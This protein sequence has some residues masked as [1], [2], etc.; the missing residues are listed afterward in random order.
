MSIV[1][2]HEGDNRITLR[3]LIDQGVRVH[4]VCTDPPYGLVSIKK[5]FGKA[6]AAPAKFGTDGAFARAGA[7]F[8]GSEWD[9]T[10][11]ERDPEFWRLIWEILLP[12]GYCLAFS[13]AS[14]GH[15]QACA[16]ELAGFTMHPMIGWTFGS[17][18]PK[19]HDAAKAIDK[20]LGAT[21]SF[22][23]PKSDAHAGWIKRGRMRGGEDALN[24]EG[25]QRPW[26]ED[27]QA[28]SN[29]ARQYIPATE[30]G[31]QWDGWSYGAQALKPALEPI[32]VGQKPFSEKNG[33]LN[34]LKHGA[35]AV[36]IDGCRVP[37]DET[38]A[39][40]GGRRPDT[41]EGYQ[42]PNASMFQDK[43]D[44]S[45]PSLGRH[46][47]NLITD[48]SDEVRALFPDSNGQQG[49]VR[50]T[51]PS[52][53]TDEIYGKFAGRVPAAKRQDTDTSA[54]RFF[55]AFPLDAES[56][57]YHAKASKRDRIYECRTCGNHAIG[58]KPSCTCAPNIRTHPTV[59][60]IGLM[61]HLVKLVTPPGGTVLDCFAGTGT[62][63]RAAQ[64]LGFN[65][66]LLEADPDFCRDIRLRCQ[67][68][69]EMN[70]ELTVV[71]DPHTQSLEDLIGGVSMNDLK[72]LIG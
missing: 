71:Q 4:A 35:G 11:I 48:G 72:E 52:G 6:N 46:P 37:T 67:I 51:E 15:W 7:G 44:W 53:V 56:L 9:G 63:G 10:G 17:G 49:D 2:L 54:A 25:W 55:N 30:E 36:N 40:A 50:G 18:F 64:N 22:G 14:T 60:P 28:V 61:E 39:R 69:D 29:N 59:K 34:L 20:Q 26:M 31:A 3:R 38:S 42:R 33:A 65:A 5:R 41:H 16:M 58:A 47:A 57:Y 24:N 8:M 23:D 12:G 21:G 68:G 62:T 32:Y 70:A 13:G 45:L 43:S 66:I 1:T 19:D 27:E